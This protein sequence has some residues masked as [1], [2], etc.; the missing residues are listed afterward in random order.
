MGV[1]T[2]LAH[3][4]QIND[5]NGSIASYYASFAFGEQFLTSSYSWSGPVSAT[6]G[7]AP[8]RMFWV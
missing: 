2:Q 4:K 5:V 3:L 6:P 8:Y 1:I 7:D